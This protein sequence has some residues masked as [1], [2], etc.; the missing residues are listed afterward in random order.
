MDRSTMPSE[1]S[2]ADST[3]SRRRRIVRPLVD[4][5]RTESSSGVLLLL[6]TVIALV[7]ANSTWSSSYVDLLVHPLVNGLGMHLDVQEF[8]NDALM[9]VFFFVVGLEITRELVRGELR[10]P[11]AAALPVIAAIGGMVVPALIYVGFN[12]GGA[13]AHGWGIPM[14]TDIAFAV[15]V[16]VLFGRR[17]P[18]SLKLFLLALAVVD[19]LGAII[20]IAVFYSGS[21]AVLW[22]LGAAAVLGVLVGCRRLPRLFP[23]ALPVLGVVVWYCVLRS[24]VHAT[25]A[26]VALAFVVPVDRGVD[27]NERLHP[28][29]ARVIVPVFALCN[30]GIVLGRDA[31]HDALSSSVT[32]GVLFGL[33]AGK[34]LGVFAAAA[35]AIALGIA[36][37][38]RGA[39]NLHLLAVAIVAGIGF[40]VSLFITGLAFGDPGLQN[41]AKIGIL[42]ASVLAAAGAALVMALA[43][44]ETPMSPEDGDDA[45]A[46]T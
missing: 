4:F 20:V 36:V 13:G 1:R 46:S 24:G 30:A 15:G 12:V 14:A 27:L 37:R 9:A 6:A 28:I 29:S 31:L 8:V 11:R 44:R 38:P 10:E 18:T 40:T 22:L 5:L 42:V 21:V 7:W 3:A 26:G 16:L 35:G 2:V 45:P 17:V 32:H 23:F 34:T 41:D 19:D 43:Q 25:I 39:T 33:V